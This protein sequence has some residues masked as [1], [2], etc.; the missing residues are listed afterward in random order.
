MCSSL[1]KSFHFCNTHSHFHNYLVFVVG[2]SLIYSFVSTRIYFISTATFFKLLPT[3]TK[4]ILISVVQGKSYSLLLFSLFV[5]MII[6]KHY[7]TYIVSLHLYLKPFLFIQI[8]H[9][10]RFKLKLHTRGDEERRKTRKN[11]KSPFCSSKRNVC[12]FG[13]GIQLNLLTLFP[14]SAI[15]SGNQTRNQIG[16]PAWSLQS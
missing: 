14:V 15:L 2:I 12:C 3:I 6:S 9:K 11:E 4:V 13:E 7:S 10:I 1:S 16:E 5:L 8:P